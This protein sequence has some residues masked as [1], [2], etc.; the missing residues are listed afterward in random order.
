MRKHCTTVHKAPA[1]GLCSLQASVLEATDTMTFNAIQEQNMP[2]DLFPNESYEFDFANKSM[3][4]VGYHLLKLEVQH[5]LPQVALNELCSTTMFYD[6]TYSHCFQQLSS[7]YKR[8]D[9]FV[10]SF[11]LVN[12]YPLAIN[13][14][15][16][17]IVNTYHMAY[18]VPFLKSLQALLMLPEVYDCVIKPHAV[19]PNYMTDFCDAK[20][21]KNHGILKT[22]GTLQIIIS[23]DD[24]TFSNPLGMNA[25]RH[26][27]IIFSYSLANIPPCLRSKIHVHQ[28]L[29]IAQSKIVHQYGYATVLKDFLMA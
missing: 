19:N 7:Q 29:A 9:F 10:K 11:D 21:V 14:A 6:N 26:S 15:Q 17:G 13:H 25:K 8:N 24:V 28:L 23:V 4:Q 22:F 16:L 1:K 18:I 5:S 20:F 27:L 3:L 12:S 2:I